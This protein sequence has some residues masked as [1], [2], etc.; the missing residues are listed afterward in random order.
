MATNGAGRVSVTR[1]I[2]APAETI[3]AVLVDPASHVSIDGSGMVR[4]ALTSSAITEVGGDAFVMGM[5]HDRMGSYEMAN[6]VVEFEVNR[7]LAWEPRPHR[8][9]RDLGEIGDPGRYVWGYQLTPVDP[10]TTDVTETFDCSRSPE[11]LR[12]ATK[13]GEGWLE[14]MTTSLENLEQLVSG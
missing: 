3:F 10:T 2:A 6:T 11:W 5:Y 12:E 1:R 7:R 9:S 8:A 14:A 4:T 13:E